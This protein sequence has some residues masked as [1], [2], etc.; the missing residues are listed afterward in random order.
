MGAL[1]DMKTKRGNLITVSWLRWGNAKLQDV[2]HAFLGPA[3]LSLHQQEVRILLGWLAVQ[4][5]GSVR[6]ARALSLNT[7]SQNQGVDDSG[8]PNPADKFLS[9]SSRVSKKCFGW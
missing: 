2:H 1:R 3:L 5:T 8:L 4:E 7:A 9:A 6:S